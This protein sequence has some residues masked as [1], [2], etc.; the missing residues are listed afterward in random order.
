[1]SL[2]VRR[3]TTP[4]AAV[5]RTLA[6]DANASRETTSAQGNGNGGDANAS[7]NAEPRDRC[8]RCGTRL[9]LT[10]RGWGEQSVDVMNMSAGVQVCQAC[11]VGPR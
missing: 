10:L 3:P 2:A 11:L 5:N 1:M 4:P 8:L 7:P 6:G 9:D